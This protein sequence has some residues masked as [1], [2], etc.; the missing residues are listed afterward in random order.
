MLCYIMLACH[1]GPVERDNTQ[2]NCDNVIP[3]AES[4]S[5][6]FLKSSS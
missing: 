2:I 4:S 6:Q 1:E 3:D 5:S